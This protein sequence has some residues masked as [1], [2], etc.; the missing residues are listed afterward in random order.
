MYITSILIGGQEWIDVVRK[1]ATEINVESNGK[2][3]TASIEALVDV[4]RDGS[5]YAASPQDA[6][7]ILGCA[8]PN[9]LENHS[10]E[11]G[12][13]HW[14]GDAGFARDASVKFT[15]SASL[16]GT[17]VSGP[18]GI[19]YGQFV[20][21]DPGEKWYATAWCKENTTSIAQV[22]LSWFNEAKNSF[23]GS[24]EVNV[25]GNTWAKYKTNSVAPA[26]AAWVRLAYRLAYD[27]TGD[28]WID[29]ATLSKAD[30]QVL[31]SGYAARVE[32]QVTGPQQIRYRIQCQD[33]MRILDA[34]VVASETYS[35]S[36]AKEIIEDLAATYT[37]SPQSITTDGVA[38]DV[39]LLDGGFE[40]TSGG[41]FVD[42]TATAGVSVN[43]TDKR[44]G[45]SCAQITAATG[46]FRGVSQTFNSAPGRTYRLTGYG[47]E[48]VDGSCW[49]VIDFLDAADTGISNAVA[50]MSG[51]SWTPYTATGTAPANTAKVKAQVLVGDDCTT[52]RVLADDIKFSLVLPSITFENLSLRAC[53]DRICDRTGAEWRLGFDGDLKYYA[54][55]LHAGAFSF[56]DAADGS[57]TEYCLQSDFGYQEEFSQPANAASVVGYQAPKPDQGNIALSVGASA[58]DGFVQ[59]LEIGAWPP[60]ENL[61]VNTNGHVLILF[62]S[63]NLVTDAYSFSNG[64]IRFS[65]SGIPSGATIVSATLRLYGVQTSGI[66][67]RVI[68]GDYFPSASWPIGVEDYL[69]TPAVATGYTPTAVDWMDLAPLNLGGFGGV[70][71]LLELPLINLNNIPS[72]G[73]V[74]FRLFVGDLAAG[75]SD[76]Y[77]LEIA[78]FDSPTARYRPVL[79][80]AYQEPQP[81]PIAGYAEDAASIALYGTFA[82]TITDAS[83]TTVG[84]ADARAAVETV[85]YGWPRQSINCT[86]DR[87]GL[88][89]G[90]TVHFTSSLLGIDDEFV[91]KRLRIRWPATQDKTR[92]SAELGEFR[93]DLIDYLRKV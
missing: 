78:S 32:P 48:T 83:V 93:P 54:V 15:G 38:S 39:A 34:I 70:P 71:T 27:A 47:R 49:L 74:G 23:L 19:L 17:H 79:V 3:S 43:T 28:A 89:V 33:N 2:A 86:F 30:E 50:T 42:W 87:D 61:T 76:S 36:T 80:V 1:E 64:F 63:C 73:Y 81:A 66:Y 62:S 5:G 58:D 65:V 21:C 8:E 59:S 40:N 46:A 37:G 68:G 41:A 44:T 16:K 45:V 26:G 14:S 90:D 51:D 9:R 6:V 4:T 12:L 82:K 25:T 67:T 31:F 24:D 84:E 56:S 18:A 92:Y 77:Q 91:V 88:N 10:F 52:G 13:A 11:N 29:Q 72:T 57:T 69:R 53:L 22:V 20:R 35:D 7:V 55:G 75:I 60:D 85:R